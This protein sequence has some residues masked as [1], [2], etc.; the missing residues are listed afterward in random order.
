MGSRWRRTGVALSAL[1]ALDHDIEDVADGAARARMAPET[2]RGSGG[3]RTRAGRF[4]RGSENPAD[5]RCSQ[6]PART[7]H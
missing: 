7:D 3:P 1:V 6:D 5:T 4:W 2:D